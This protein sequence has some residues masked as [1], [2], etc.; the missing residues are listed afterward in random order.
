MASA[1]LAQVR[2]VGEA[3]VP[4]GSQIPYPERSGHT[5]LPVVLPAFGLRAEPRDPGS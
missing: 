5:P 3:T 4:F 2:A 1:A